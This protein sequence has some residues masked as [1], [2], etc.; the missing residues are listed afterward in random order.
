MNE[1]FLEATYKGSLTSFAFKSKLIVCLVCFVKVD[2]LPE[3]RYDCDPCK[4]YSFKIPPNN[5]FKI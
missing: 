4:W 2:E 3:S 1:L 5:D